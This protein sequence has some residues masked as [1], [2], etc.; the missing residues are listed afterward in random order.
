[1][2][3]AIKEYLAV[4][5]RYLPSIY[6]LGLTLNNKTGYSIQSEIFSWDGEEANVNSYKIYER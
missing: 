5:R 2:T 6:A 4:V 1:V 3:A